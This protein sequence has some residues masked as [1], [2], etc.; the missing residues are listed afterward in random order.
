MV[1]PRLVHV[2]Q[3]SRGA[4]EELD[5]VCNSFEPVF[6]QL[7]ETRKVNHWDKLYLIKN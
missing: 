1:L 5:L 4:L 2:E 3:S 6:L 7:T